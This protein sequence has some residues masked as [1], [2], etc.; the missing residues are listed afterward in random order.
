ME[1]KAGEK[2][3]QYTIEDKLGKGAFGAVY[4]V[5]HKTRS[6]AL[7]VENGQSKTMVEWE[8]KVMKH[9]NKTGATART[10]GL[11]QGSVNGQPSTGLCMDM[12]GKSL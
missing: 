8:H 9:F 4:K 3:G 12:M 10:F 1:L 11:T 7:K 5:K 2:F 6:Y